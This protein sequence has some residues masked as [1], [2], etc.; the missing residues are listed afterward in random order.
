MLLV[1][2]QKPPKVDSMVKKVLK[3]FVLHIMYIYDIQSDSMHRNH[4]KRS[5]NAKNSPKNGSLN[6]LRGMVYVI[7]DT[8]CPLSIGFRICMPKRGRG[9][10]RSSY[11]RPKSTIFSIFVATQMRCPKPTTIF[12]WELNQAGL[13]VY[14]SRL[15]QFQ[16]SG[17]K[18]KK[19]SVILDTSYFLEHN[20][21]LAYDLTLIGLV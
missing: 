2:D 6:F 17:T 1:P 4:P 7:P 18:N 16:A 12:V 19:V 13:Q 8:P 3:T 20:R 21:F 15:I 14:E 10:L 11:G 5:E 9:C